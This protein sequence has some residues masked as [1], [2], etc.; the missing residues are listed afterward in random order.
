MFFIGDRKKEGANARG[1]WAE[2][3]LNCFIRD[4]SQRKKKL[5]GVRD[6]Q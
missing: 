6:D 2:T 5:T 1:Q 4:Q 3:A